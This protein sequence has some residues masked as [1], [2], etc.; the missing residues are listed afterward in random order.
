M[1]TQFEVILWAAA[2]CVADVALADI[3]REDDDFLRVAEN[4][5]LAE[6]HATP[7]SI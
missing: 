5:C 6:T 2:I 7:Y 4:A 1:A 3:A